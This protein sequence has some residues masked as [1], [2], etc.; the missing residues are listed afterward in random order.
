MKFL[1][2]IGVTTN[3]TATWAINFIIVSTHFPKL[4]RLL[5]A[6]FFSSH[7]YPHSPS[8]PLTPSET[9]FIKI[10]L[11]TCSEAIRKARPCACAVERTR[12]NIKQPDRKLWSSRSAG[13]GQGNTSA[14]AVLISLINKF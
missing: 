4:Y 8:P 6:F 13:R 12:Q 14:S 9:C 2:P 1:E 7:S 3:Y 11:W 5:S 10:V